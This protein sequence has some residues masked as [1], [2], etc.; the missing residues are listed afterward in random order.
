METL[1]SQ[2]SVLQSRINPDDESDDDPICNVIA[3]YC[4]GR[5]FELISDVRALLCLTQ[6]V[7]ELSYRMLVMLTPMSFDIQTLS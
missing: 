2:W 4:N 6:L 5:T 7:P 3:K 1:L